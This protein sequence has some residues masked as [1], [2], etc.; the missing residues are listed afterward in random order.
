[1]DP[2]TEGKIA[3]EEVR[4]SVILGP[5]ALPLR[6]L[7]MLHAFRAVSHVTV[8]MNMMISRYPPGVS[9]SV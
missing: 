7:R 9:S 2:N 8:I 3:P 5:G 6:S 1:M 4:R